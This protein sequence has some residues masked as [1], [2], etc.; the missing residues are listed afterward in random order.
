MPTP[1]MPAPSPVGRAL[2]LEAASGNNT[3]PSQETYPGNDLPTTSYQNVQTVAA[4]HPA[5]VNR[6]RIGISF[7]K[8]KLACKKKN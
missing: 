6:L 1:P 7:D 8:Y 3:T 2:G 5:K 4:A